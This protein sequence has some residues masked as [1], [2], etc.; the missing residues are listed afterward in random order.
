[1]TGSFDVSLGPAESQR[2]RLLFYFAEGAVAGAIFFLLAYTVSV[3]FSVLGFFTGTG[4][5]FILLLLLVLL[6]VGIR[7]FWAMVLTIRTSGLPPVY[8]EWNTVRRWSLVVVVAVSIATGLF[9][10]LVL[11]SDWQWGEYAQIASWLAMGTLL[12]GFLLLAVVGNSA[13][14]QD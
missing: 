4:P 2:A 11:L 3:L 8:Q 6:V 10:V 14:E 1:M 5:G 13:I 9:G 7:S 12:L